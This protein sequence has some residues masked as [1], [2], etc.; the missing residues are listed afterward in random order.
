[1]IVRGKT[2]YFPPP[3]VGRAPWELRFEPWVQALRLPQSTPIPQRIAG[4]KGVD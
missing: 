1:M 2:I 3:G 4:M